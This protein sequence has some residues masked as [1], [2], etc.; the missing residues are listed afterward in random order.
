MLHPP[1]PC[2]RGSSRPCSFLVTTR[3]YKPSP[4]LRMVRPW[5]AEPTMDCSCCGAWMVRCDS[6]FLI[7]PELL[8]WPGLLQENS[9]QV[10]QERACVSLMDVLQLRSHQPA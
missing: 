2:Q 8:L 1:R 4:G 5:Q 3:R 6:R 7:L 9:W 10:D